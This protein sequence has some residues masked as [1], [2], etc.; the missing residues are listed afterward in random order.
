MLND[1]D[2]EAI[3]MLFPYSFNEPALYY[4]DKRMFAIVFIKNGVRD[5]HY[6]D[7]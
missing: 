5:Q 6:S 7:L 2:S 4:L 3:N 1:L